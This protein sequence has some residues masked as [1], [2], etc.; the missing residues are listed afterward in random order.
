MALS[1]YIR[2]SCF[3]THTDISFAL[4]FHDLQKRVTLGHLRILPISGSARHEDTRHNPPHSPS[5]LRVR[6][7]TI[8]AQKKQKRKSYLGFNVACMLSVAE[9]PAFMGEDSDHCTCQSRSEPQRG[10]PHDMSFLRYRCFAKLIRNNAYLTY[11]QPLD[12]DKLCPL[13]GRGR[14]GGRYQPFSS[15]CGGQVGTA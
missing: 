6:I 2:T 14:C 15:K 7:V 12:E 5:H 11:R 1:I 10:A 3:T 8:L 4:S 9:G 13:A